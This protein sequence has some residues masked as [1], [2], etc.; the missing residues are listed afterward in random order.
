M[1]NSNL[2][3]KAGVFAASAIA[4]V[5]FAATQ[6][7]V[8]QA[9]PTV[10]TTS[11]SPDLTTAL[12]DIAQTLDPQVQVQLEA[13]DVAFGRTPDQ[14]FS[15]SQALDAALA[16]RES[17]GLPEAMVA[18][19]I[20]VSLQRVTTNSFG[21]DSNPD[22]SGP[23]KITPTINGDSVWVVAFTSVPVP[24]FGRSREPAQSRGTSVVFLE[25]E[26]LKFIYSLSF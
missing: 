3:I 22:P 14:A 25:P 16:A 5:T 26:T 2:R 12:P 1:K 23:S 24:D 6:Q 21:V 19:P 11:N 17:L 20:E 10:T 8:A 15:D 13:L 4:L 9:E 18:T 7:G